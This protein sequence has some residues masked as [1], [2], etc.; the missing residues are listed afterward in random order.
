MRNDPKQG[1]WPY[2]EQAGE[3]PAM[4]PNGVVRHEGN[5]DFA[6]GSVAKDKATG[7]LSWRPGA[8]WRGGNRS[9][10]G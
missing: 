1:R 8:E 7:T 2:T 3:V 5:P 10:E 9:G 4:T 6:P